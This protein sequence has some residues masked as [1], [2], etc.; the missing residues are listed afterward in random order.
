MENKDAANKKASGS[1]PK[2]L[3]SFV[4]E[5]AST[6]APNTTNIE[7]NVKIAISLSNLSCLILRYTSLL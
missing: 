2:I 1:I 4:R 5:Y 7:N 6:M 3:T